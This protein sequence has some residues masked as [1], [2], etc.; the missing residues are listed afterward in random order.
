MKKNCCLMILG[1]LVITT[2]SITNPP[3]EVI[4]L[5]YGQ[6][7]EVSGTNDDL[8]DLQNI[9]NIGYYDSKIW[10]GY[11][12]GTDL[13]VKSMT[14]LTSASTTEETQATNNR[15]GGNNNVVLRIFD[16]NIYCVTLGGDADRIYITYIYST[17]GGSNWTKGVYN[18]VAV[19]DVGYTADGG[20]IVDIYEDGSDWYIFCTGG[21]GVVFD[22]VIIVKNIASQ[23]YYDGFPRGGGYWLKEMES[24]YG[25]K[26]DGSGNYDFYIH[27]TDD[28]FY[29]VTYDMSAGTYT[30]T[31]DTGLTAPASWDIDAQQYWVQ[32]NQEL[33]MDQD[34]FYYRTVGDSAWSSVSD[35]GT[36]TNGIVWY[37]DIN[38]DYMINWIIWKDSIYKIFKGGG[39]AKIQT[40]T[41]NAYVG[42][43]DW[44]ANG[45]DKIYQ[46]D[47]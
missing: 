37:Y 23:T 40:Y 43:D 26:I 20:R 2:P 41:G 12:D 44:F 29:K 6:F 7:E 42:W 46:L 5:K 25:G 36:T 24:V 47:P 4:D 27:D 30:E 9:R 45:A 28:D 19:P 31:I 14:S 15:T 16:D 11:I 18:F 10:I 35:T 22:G 32:N 39:I 38:G 1:L 17:D 21:D 33:I 13:K 34:H 3:E 8:E